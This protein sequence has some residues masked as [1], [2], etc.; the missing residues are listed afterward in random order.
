MA[1]GRSKVLESGDA[2]V[3]VVNRIHHGESL[4]P[5][6]AV[7]MVVYAGVEGLPITVRDRTPATAATAP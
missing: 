3:E 5:E 2:L 1:D 6:Q 4:G 7:I